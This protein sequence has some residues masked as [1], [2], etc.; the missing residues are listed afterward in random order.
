MSYAETKRFSLLN[1]WFLINSFMIQQ[2]DVLFEMTRA[3]IPRGGRPIDVENQLLELNVPVVRRQVGHSKQ[4]KDLMKEARERIWSARV[5]LWGMMFS[6][7]KGS[8]AERQRLRDEINDQRQVLKYCK[9]HPDLIGFWVQEDKAQYAE[10]AMLSWGLDLTM[11]LWEPRNQQ[12]AA[13]RTGP[14][15]PPFYW[16]HRGKRRGDL[17]SRMASI[18]DRMFG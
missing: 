5:A 4:Q 7:D 11:P 1:P 13:N 14:V 6:R 9:K 17:E 16:T 3:S 2:A 12:W 10:Y 8:R 15:V 18:M